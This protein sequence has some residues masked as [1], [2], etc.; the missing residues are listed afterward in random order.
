MNYDHYVAA[1]DARRLAKV[2]AKR[3]PPLAA[4]VQVPVDG[5]ALAEK[6][7]L[8]LEQLQDQRALDGLCVSC[9]ARKCGTCWACRDCEG[10]VC[11]ESDA[12]QS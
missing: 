2:V 6:C 5:D 11:G 4:P 7:A 9:G 1:L 10:C 3:L 12:V 8:E